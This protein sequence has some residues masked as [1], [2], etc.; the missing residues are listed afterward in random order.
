MWVKRKDVIEF[1]VIERV[2]KTDD[3]EVMMMM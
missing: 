1:G 2:L 3:A